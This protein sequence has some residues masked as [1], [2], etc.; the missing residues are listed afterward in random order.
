MIVFGNFAA[1]FFTHFVFLLLLGV[2]VSALLDMQ[3]L[4][5]LYVALI[6]AFL[7]TFITHMWFPRARIQ[8]LYA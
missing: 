6:G 7:I 8:R 5:N 2:Y 4:P 3:K 1:D